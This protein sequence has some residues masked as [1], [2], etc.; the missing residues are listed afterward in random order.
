[1][2]KKVIKSEKEAAKVARMLAKDLREVLAIY[3]SYE[4]KVEQPSSDYQVVVTS[5]EGGCNILTGAC[6]GNMVEVYLMYDLQYKGTSFYIDV[7]K[8]DEKHIPAFTICIGYE[9]ENQ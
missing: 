4:V 5:P 1:M 7:V 2:I 6:V 3:E 9:K 8:S